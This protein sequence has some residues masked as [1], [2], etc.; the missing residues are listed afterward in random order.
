MHQINFGINVTTDNDK[1]DSSLL[2]FVRY[3]HFVIII[4]ILYTV[5]CICLIFKLPREYIYRGSK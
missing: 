1:H 3:T 5:Y 2:E 4:I